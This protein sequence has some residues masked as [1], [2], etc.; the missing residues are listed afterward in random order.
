MCVVSLSHLGQ[1][2]AMT[3]CPSIYFVTVSYFYLAAAAGVFAA[4]V[5][6]IWKYILASS[7]LLIKFLNWPGFLKLVSKSTSDS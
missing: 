7:I 1:Q 5:V 3:G 2:M 6:F 4:V